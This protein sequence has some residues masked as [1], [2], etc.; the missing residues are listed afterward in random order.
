M[1]E[2]FSN[3]S[4]RLWMVL[5][6]FF[7]SNT[8]V[9]EF[10]GVKL[11]S[12]EKTLG[13]AEADWTLLGQPH[14]N[15]TLTAGVLLWP[16]VFI[17]TDIINE[18]YGRNGVKLLSWLTAGLILYSFVMLTFAMQLQPADFWRTS[19]IQPDWDEA[20][21]AAALAKV[22]DYNEAYNMIFGQSRWII[23]GSL[24]A[25]LLGQLVDVQVFHR[26]KQHTGEDKIWMRATGSTLVS[27]LI[28]TFVVGIIALHFGL[29]IGLAQVV[30]ICLMGYMYK[31][32]VAL[33]MTPV[34][35]L[36]HEAIE[37]YLGPELATKMKDAAAGT[38]A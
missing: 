16:M 22:G 38:A 32:I 5:A 19:H 37:R 4:N 15:F 13:F 23:A 11:F 24:I 9:A 3:R 18:Y 21:K 7:V 2:F 10:M 31:G 29:H 35:Y 26:I 1:R 33:L 12:L 28:D 30:A 14:L 8:L 25:F 20:Q 34:I 27:Q 6:G 36:I 17:M